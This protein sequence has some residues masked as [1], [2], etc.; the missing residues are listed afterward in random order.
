[1]RF[2]ALRTDGSN[3]EASAPE[4]AVRAPLAFSKMPSVKELNEGVKQVKQITI[5]GVS[6]QLAHALEEEKKRRGTSL[7]QTVLNLLKQALG[8]GPEGYD[9]GLSKFAG[10]WSR[11]ELSQFEK[12]TEMFEH[13]DAELWQ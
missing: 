9:N 8:I 1:M 2:V 6:E 13:I 10:T 12:D 4:T 5:R 7:N 3:L 11:K